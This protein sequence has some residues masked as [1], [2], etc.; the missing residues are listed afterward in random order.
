ME[1]ESLRSRA[2]PSLAPKV[3][4]AVVAELE[5][6]K[7]LVREE[8]LVR[9]P[10]HSTGLRGDEKLLAARI[11]DALNA[12]GMTPPDTAA[13]AAELNVEAGQ[14]TPLLEALERDGR[15]ARVDA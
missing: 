13:L 3:F 5:R 11:E 8:S 1:M 9:R 2:A 12:A 6:E 14:M 7:V 4:R 15:I 10:T